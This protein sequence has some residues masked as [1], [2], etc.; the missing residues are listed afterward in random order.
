MGPEE[1]ALNDRKP[2]NLCERC[3]LELEA[4]G[5]PVLE[6]YKLHKH[7]EKKYKALSDLVDDLTA[8]L[9][10]GYEFKKEEVEK[11]MKP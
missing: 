5:D 10:Y 4:T 3:F 9:G 8:L 11:A 1:R 6:V 2:F 7:L